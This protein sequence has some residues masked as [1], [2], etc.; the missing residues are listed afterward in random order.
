MSALL[1][2][3]SAGVEVRIEQDDVVAL[4]LDRLPP[5]VAGPLLAMARACRDAIRAEL[6][7]GPCP[8]SEI[9]LSA[10]TV[11]HPHLVCCPATRPHPWWWVERSWCD[12]KCKTPCGRADD[13]A[14]QKR[15]T[16]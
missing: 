3:S 16:Q 2:L 14:E 8:Y 15:I 10:F 13:A 6:L 1:K 4:G 7:V 5:E 12:T 9:E 11:S